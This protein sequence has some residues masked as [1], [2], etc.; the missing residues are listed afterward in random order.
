M[1]Q[2]DEG[3][4]IDLTCQATS[5]QNISAVAPNGMVISYCAPRIELRLDILGPFQ[6]SLSDFGS[7]LDAKVKQMESQLPPNVLAA[8]GQSPLSKVTAS[9]ILASSADV[10]VQFIATEGVTHSASVT[11]FPCS[12]QEIQFTGQGGMSAQFFGLTDSAKR[13]ADLFTKTFTR[14]DPASDFCKKV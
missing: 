9:N 13:T 2:G 4:S 1:P 11:P 6:K 3:S 8:L 12:K 10:Y 14:W 5:D 7:A